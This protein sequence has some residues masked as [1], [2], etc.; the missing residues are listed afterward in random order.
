MA[1]F[2]D[3]GNHFGKHLSLDTNKEAPCHGTANKR[4]ERQD[5]QV[6]LAVLFSL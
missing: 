6:Y 5:L 1:K 3:N 4:R 2:S